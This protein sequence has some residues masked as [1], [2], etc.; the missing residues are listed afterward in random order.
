MLVAARHLFAERGYA[1]TSNRAV[2]DA[3]G[4]THTAI[5]NHFDSKAGLFHSVFE[6]VQEVLIAELNAAMD[7]VSGRDEFPLALLSAAESLRA[8]DPSYISFMAS[9]YVEVDRHEELRAIFQGGPPFAVIGAMSRF[10]RGDDPPDGADEI[11]DALW[12]WIIFGI[13]LAQFGSLANDDLFGA[14]MSAFRA[15]FSKT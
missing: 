3:A 11:D 13:G 7:D 6:Q 1:A 15:R 2:A 14:M 12:F 8:A 5:Y 9:M 4:L 10:A